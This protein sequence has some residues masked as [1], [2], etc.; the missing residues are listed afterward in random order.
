LKPFDESGAFRPVV[1]EMRG[2]AVRGAGVTVL[3]AGLGL[4]VQ[5]VSTMILAR[6]L[7]PRDFGLVTMV[8]TFSLL[9][10]NVGLNGFTEAV[11]QREEMDHALASNLFWIN[12][13]V[14]LVLT[15]AFAGAGSLLARFYG[16]PLVAPVTVGISLT[17]F[18]TSTSV[19][20]I[21]LLKRAM[22][23]SVT[24][25]ND[26]FSA[27][28]SFTVAILLARQ[29]WGYWALVAGVVS[30]PLFQS[31]GA[32]Y[33]CRW[34]PSFPRHA[35]GTAWA[36]R[37]A[38]SV[39]GR[40]GINYFARNLDNLLVGWR[41]SAQAL[42]FYK[43]AYDLF[44]LSAGQLVAPLLNV[45]VSALSRLRHDLVQY[46]RYFLGALAVI[47]FVGMGL[48]ADLTLIGKDVIRL[49]LGPGWEQ[50]GRIFT[51]F[52][53][54]I[55]IMILYYT[56]GWIHLSIGKPD[57][58]LYWGI[59]EFV[60]TALSF[61]VG[62]HWGP[63]GVAAAWTLS[64]W[65]LAVPAFWYAGRPIRLGVGS[66]IAA[67]WRYPIASLL[68]GCATAWI[69][70][71][72]PWFGAGSGALW[73]AARI[74]MI[75]VLFGALYCGAV[76]LMFGGLDP[77]YQ[78]ASLLREMVPWNKLAKASEAA[79]TPH[80]VPGEPFATPAGSEILYCSEVSSFSTEGHVPRGQQPRA[81]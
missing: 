36:V 32:W 8:T 6:L 47:A 46:K 2:L 81:S 14:G 65:I 5:I 49:L 68:A 21:A 12:V 23:F 1:G 60:F 80:T 45:A 66:I 39:Y 29:G 55:G 28:L 3:S 53:P 10:M 67:V 30:L 54:G 64:F 27:A 58:W 72:V 40:F 38:M 78:L 74:A 15:V 71:A 17:I 43:K 9:L 79:A 20:H 33:Q 57:R 50:A 48:G 26:I 75:S 73:A 34:V 63:L 51:Y 69:V 61:V 18:I 62:L 35:A 44:A 42:G 77:F 59:F 11:L 13:G 31:I 76:G 7:T 16:N 4:A 37:F 52:G 25:A 24:S 70:A 22:R 19:I 41:F 56:Y